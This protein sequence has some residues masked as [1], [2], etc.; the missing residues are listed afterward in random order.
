MFSF[1]AE[2]ENV[3]LVDFLLQET[4]RNLFGDSKNL[5]SE[6][7][8]KLSKKLSK[9]DLVASSSFNPTGEKRKVDENLVNTIQSNHEAI[10][11]IRN[12][13]NDLKNDVDQIRTEMKVRTSNEHLNER[14][15]SKVDSTRRATS[16]NRLNLKENGHSVRSSLC[17]LL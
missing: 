9:A 12:Q 7:R 11:S 13:I 14:R 6:P 17:L 1:S 3:F 4:L 15:N 8:E 5:N 16:T 2:N 10:G